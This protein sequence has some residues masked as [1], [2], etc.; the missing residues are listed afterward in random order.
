MLL[1]SRKPESVMI[2]EI[3]NEKLRWILVEDSFLPHSIVLWG[4]MERKSQQ[5][6]HPFWEVPVRGFLCFSPPLT[7]SPSRDRSS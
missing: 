7:C 2:S 4:P 6:F 1:I 3:N 5:P